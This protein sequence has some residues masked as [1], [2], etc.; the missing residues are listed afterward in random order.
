MCTNPKWVYK[1]GQRKID[2]YNGMK[3]EGFEIGI[4]AKCGCCDQCNS[5][6]ANAWVVRN[7]REA[8]THKDISFITLTYAKSPQILLRKDAQDFMKRLRKKL[9]KEYNHIKI[10]MFGA[11][12]YGE[13]GRPHLH[14]IIYGWREPKKIY[15]GLNKKKNILWKS[16]LIEK[17]WG[18]GRTTIDDLEGHAIPYLSLYETP[19]EKFAKAYKLTLE[20]TRILKSKEF[21]KSL[22]KGTRKNLL[23]EIKLIEKEL[24]ITK[25]KYYAVKEFNCWSIGL[26]WENFIN[27]YIKDNNYTWKEYIEDKEFPTPI[28]WVKRIANEYGDISA[29]A[30][31]KRRE[32]IAIQSINE[33]EEKVKNLIKEQGRTKEKIIEHHQK[34]ERELE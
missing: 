15:L 18:K 26:G 11:G 19:K 27:E 2:S 16:E 25:E 20:K 1:K 31:I 17:V 34:N 9:D 4:F 32:R 10:R 14:F 24:K 33:D 12:E 21:T 13:K 3:G 30:E 7:T 22:T 28:S 8:K 5:E 23:E 29:V 6:R